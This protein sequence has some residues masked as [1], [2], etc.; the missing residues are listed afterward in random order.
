[1]ERLMSKL[2]VLTVL[3][4]LNLRCGLGLGIK[5]G[6]GDN[7]W[8][9]IERTIEN[10]GQINGDGTDQEEAFDH[11]DSLP[12]CKKPQSP[13]SMSAMAKHYQPSKFGYKDGKVELLHCYYQTVYPQLMERYRTKVFRMVEIGLDSGA[14]SLLWQEYFPC[15]EI[16][17]IEKKDAAVHTT[18]AESIHTAQ[19]DQEDTQFLQDF[20]QQTGGGFSLIIDDGGH[21]PE[22]QLN[23]YKI[24]FAQ[25][26]LPGGTYIIEDIE[27]SYWQ[28]GS[29]IYGKPISVGGINERDVV[30]NKFR[31]AVH[32]VNRKFHDNQYTVNGDMDQ[33]I[34]SITFS[35]NLVI[36]QKKSHA[37]CIT[38][39]FYVWPFRLAD[40]SPAKRQGRQGDANY[41]SPLGGVCK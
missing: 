32:V 18:G 27:T 33:W 30:I 19:G 40:G 29:E 7:Q 17:G 26:L 9:R 22:Q 6:T 31:E 36:L 4:V 13:R 23:S 41:P 28:K 35:M 20:V 3:S 38:E 15:A 2:F 37:D 12:D 25:A 14:G 5:S 8:I 39:D 24:L 10:P 1:M 16:Y 21:T 34:K 11:F